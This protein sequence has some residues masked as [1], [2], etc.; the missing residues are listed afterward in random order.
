[1]SLLKLW[2]L[3]KSALISFSRVPLTVFYAIALLAGVAFLGLSA[4]AL[5]HKHL[6]GR[7]IPGWASH[8]IVASFFGSINSLG[9]AILGEYVVRIYDQVRNRPLYLIDR[10]VNFSPKPS[11]P[12]NTERNS[13]NSEK[14][15]LSK[16]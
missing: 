6:T 4:F 11:S 2:R 7:A 16:Q 5:Y 15:P 13:S 8:V 3:A 1:M 12:D 10:K 9:I 14:H